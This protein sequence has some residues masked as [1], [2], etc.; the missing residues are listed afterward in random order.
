MRGIEEAV[1]LLSSE[2]DDLQRSRSAVY[3][4]QFET[5][6]RVPKMKE[7][8]AAAQTERR[9]QLGRAAEAAE[10]RDN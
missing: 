9:K 6:E 3:A 8:L 10:E 5:A 1:Y 4:R 7:R 2:L